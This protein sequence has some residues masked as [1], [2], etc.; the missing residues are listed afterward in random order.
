MIQQ[1]FFYLLPRNEKETIPRIWV[2]TSWLHSVCR[3]ISIRK[4]ANF[5]N[6][7]LS[8]FRSWPFVGRFWAHFSWIC[9]LHYLPRYWRKHIPPKLWYACIRLHNVT[10]QNT[11]I[12]K[13][14]ETGRQLDSPFL[15]TVYTNL[16]FKTDNVFSKTRISFFFVEKGPAAEATD[17]PQPW[18]LLCNPVMEMISFFVFSL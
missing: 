18:G 10:S 1:C 8:K 4:T 13:L 16:Q 12:F 15:H 17:A 14:H 5:Q 3:N 11:V 2:T 6:N 9:C 7:N